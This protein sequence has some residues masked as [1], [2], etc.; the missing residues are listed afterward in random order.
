MLFSS[1]KRAFNST[2]T[3]TCLPFSAACASAAMIGEFPLTRYSVCLIASTSG[4]LLACRIKSTTGTK[5]WYGWCISTS[6][7][8]ITSKILSVPS[9]S[10]TGAGVYFGARSSSKP[11]NPYTFIKKVRS[12]GPSISKTSSLRTESSRHRIF[13]SRLSAAASIS[14]RI[15]CPQVLFLICFS[16]SRSRSSASSSSIARSAFRVIRNGCAHRTL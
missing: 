3:E 8:L 5:L 11:S 15:A 7:F 1:S 2:R 9:N 6:P 4:S 12:R 16:I 13:N 14:R 10:G